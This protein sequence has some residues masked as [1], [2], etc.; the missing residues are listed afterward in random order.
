MKHTI[1][2]KLDFDQELKE[3][4]FTQEKVFGYK[5]YVQ[6][7]KD[8]L[9]DNN[10]VKLKGTNCLK[11]LL[12][13]QSSVKVTEPVYQIHRLIVNEV[14]LTKNLTS[15]LALRAVVD[16]LVHCRLMPSIVALNAA[17]R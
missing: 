12:Q 8:Q 1:T 4:M 9:K 17:L 14:H 10:I 5:H 13:Y 3:V 15:A 11:D 7:L 2:E 16:T 6:Q